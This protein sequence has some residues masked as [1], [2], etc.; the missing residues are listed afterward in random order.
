MLPSATTTTPSS[1]SAL[2]TGSLSH[3]PVHRNVLISEHT[4]DICMSANCWSGDKTVGA[5]AWPRVSDGHNR[6]VSTVWHGTG[7]P[8]SQTAV[9]AEGS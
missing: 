2:Y 1:T 8:S 5:R 9:M 6:P 4:L 7:T 3:C